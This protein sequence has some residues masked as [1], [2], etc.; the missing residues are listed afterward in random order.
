VL[1]GT[2]YPTCYD[3]VVNCYSP[4]ASTG[5]IVTIN[6][7]GSNPILTPPATQTGVINT[8]KSGNAASELLPTG[9]L[10]AYT[11]TNG[12]SDPACVAPVGATPLPL[13][14][15]LTINAVTGAYSYTRPNA[16]GT[17]YFCVKV[18]DSSSPTPF[19]SVA[20]YKVVVTAPP[21]NAGTTPPGVN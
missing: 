20:V 17:Y 10:G 12:S 15:A 5:V 19:C 9:G 13:S 2:Y 16:V 18:C 6:P 14:S 21:C 1:G 3:V 7:C 8:V 11:Y 4:V